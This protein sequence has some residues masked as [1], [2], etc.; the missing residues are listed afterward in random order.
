[1]IISINSKKKAERNV[2][3]NKQIA[4]FNPIEIFTGM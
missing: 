1:M 2:S 4:Q 3:Q